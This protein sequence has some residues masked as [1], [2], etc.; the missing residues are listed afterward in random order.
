MSRPAWLSQLHST[1][2]DIVSSQQW[3]RQQAWIIVTEILMGFLAAWGLLQDISPLWVGLGLGLVYAVN[4]WSLWAIRVYGRKAG[5]YVMVAGITVLILSLGF[6]GSLRWLRWYGLCAS[7][8]VLLAFRDNQNVTS[9]AWLPVRAIKRGGNNMSSL[10]ISAILGAI[11]LGLSLYISGWITQWWKW[12]PHLMVVV[13][14]GCFVPH[15]V[16]QLGKGMG[17]HPS[18]QWR[19]VQ[20]E[21]MSWLLKLG[22]IFNAVN[23]LGRRLVI[24][25]MIIGLAQS[26]LGSDN[27]LPILG[28]ALGLIGILSSLARAPVVLVGKVSSLNLLKWGARLSLT[29]WAI[30]CVCLLLQA[31]SWGQSNWTFAALVLGWTMMEFTNR[32]WSIA[33]ME[34][35]RVWT[36][37]PRFSAARAHRRSLHRFMVRK[38]AGGAVGCVLG[39]MAGTTLAPAMVVVLLAGCWW[40]LEKMPPDQSP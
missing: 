25:T 6:G 16:S 8:G 4:A 13:A 15:M 22:T 23:F 35:L 40:L 2:C 9:M 29:G 24:P 1:L 21:E 28:G 33:Y 37:G 11:L 31:T 34:Q 36:V 26:K 3:W 32:T 10:T 18:S 38:S 19:A 12:L 5:I 7:I 39:G 30:L 27:V 14:Y 20:K 17:L